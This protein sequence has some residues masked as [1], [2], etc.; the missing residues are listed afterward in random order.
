MG[1]LQKIKELFSSEVKSPAIVYR[2]K[3]R[4]K[5]T[6]DP[7]IKWG[8][9]VSLDGSGDLTVGKYCIITHNVK[10]FTHMHEGL[11]DGYAPNLIATTTK[12][13]PMPLVIED[14]VFIGENAVILPQ[15]NTIGHHAIIGAYAV[16]TKNVGP[17]EVWAGNPARLIRTRKEL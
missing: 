14:N 5:I 3:L 8:K 10:I 12:E 11:K 16:V 9:N 6:L 4:G 1:I 7:S 13:I 17:G 2:S 15:V